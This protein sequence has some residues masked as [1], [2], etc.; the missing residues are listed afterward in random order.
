MKKRHRD[1]EAP[2]VSE[3]KAEIPAEELRRSEEAKIAAW[4]HPFI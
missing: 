4:T 3:P 1:D 2:P